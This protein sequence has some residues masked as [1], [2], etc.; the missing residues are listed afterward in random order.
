MWPRKPDS[1]EKLRSSDDLAIRDAKRSG[2]ET[3]SYSEM[4]CPLVLI[5][6]D[7]TRCGATYLFTSA[8]TQPPLYG[9]ESVTCWPPSILA[10][11]WRQSPPAQV[12]VMTPD[13]TLIHVISKEP[14]AS[15]RFNF[16]DPPFVK[17]NA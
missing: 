10:G 14:D 17:Y 8:A 3:S 15:D 6:N 7:V 16:T 4:T 1:L 12:R 9:A 13:E 5:V 11:I 2:R